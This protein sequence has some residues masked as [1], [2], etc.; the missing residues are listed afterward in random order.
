MGEAIKND[1]FAYDGASPNL[2][3]LLAG[4][5]ETSPG[6][7]PAV[8]RT[9]AAAR[10]GAWWFGLRRR[11]GL[12]W[13][14]PYLV[15]LPAGYEADPGKRWPLILYLHSG[16]KRGKNLALLRGEGLA[17]AVARGRQLPAL[18]ISPQCP[19]G[20]DWSTLVLSYLLDEVCARYRL[21]PDRIYVTG[22][23]LGGDAVWDVA[24][25]YPERVAAIV[26]IS[27]EGDGA[28]AARIR[29][30]P[31]WAFHGRED[32][33]VPASET[34]EMVNAVRKAGGRPH[35]SLISGGHVVWDQVYALDSLYTWLLAQ[36]RGQPE[37]ITPGVPD[38]DFSD[39]L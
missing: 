29:D 23:S 10:N 14:Y 19:W 18:V 38:A 8:K 31:A 2:G 35:L 3:I 6:D 15:D 39:S 12:S 28:D 9:N 24:L 16:V 5:S 20:E 1:F 11:L 21:D 36:K 37:V 34:I 25:A 7:P 26:P 32:R 27:G 17:R 13:H 4:L 22:A 30:L 33:V